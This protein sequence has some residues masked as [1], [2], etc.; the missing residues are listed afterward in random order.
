MYK[1]FS[2]EEVIAAVDDF[3]VKSGLS[4]NTLSRYRRFGFNYYRDG[5]SAE[6][7]YFYSEDLAESL[8]VKFH[9]QVLNGQQSERDFR[10]I[11]KVHELM[12]E[13]V[14]NGEILYHDLPFWNI[15]YPCNDIERSTGQIPCKHGTVGLLGTHNQGC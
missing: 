5:F 13:Y 15:K 4:D 3:L 11:R 1:N 14:K 12:K 9:Q 2:L 7:C 10:T 6:G 8:V